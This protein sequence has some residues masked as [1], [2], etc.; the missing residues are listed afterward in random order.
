MV[1]QISVNL[2]AIA[3]AF[4]QPEGKSENFLDTH[5][6]RILKINYARMW[7]EEIA[8]TR[9]LIGS[10]RDGRYVAIPK[11]DARVIVRDMADF[12][13]TVQDARVRKALE[14]ALIGHR[15]NHNFIVVLEHY[16]PERMR[17]YSFKDARMRERV[18]KWMKSVGIASLEAE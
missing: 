5:T 2:G 7:D 1:K 3:N 9:L 18:L 12:A 16:T 8:A 10:D 4:E 11:L 17:W 13:K 6:G 14:R 15:R